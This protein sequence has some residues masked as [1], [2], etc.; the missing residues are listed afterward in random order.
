MVHSAFISAQSALGDI[1]IEA[2]ELAAGID[3]LE[4]WVGRV[5]ADD[6]LLAIGHCRAGEK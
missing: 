2:E 3:I 1:H 4:G 6:I 5:G